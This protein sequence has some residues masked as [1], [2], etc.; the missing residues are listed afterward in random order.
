[1]YYY[2]HFMGCKLGALMS[3]SSILQSKK[4]CFTKMKILKINY[5]TNFI[6]QISHM[7]CFF[8]FIHSDM[9]PHDTE[10]QVKTQKKLNNT[11]TWLNQL[12]N[13]HILRRDPTRR[14]V[15]LQNNPSIGWVHPKFTHGLPLAWSN[16]KTPHKTAFLI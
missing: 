12:P 13:I 15:G 4:P 14:W 10:R 5:H 16:K 9:K 6:L 8:H 2:L 7:N 3:S 1:L 11:D